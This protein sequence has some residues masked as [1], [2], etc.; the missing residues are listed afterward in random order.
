MKKSLIILF[1]LIVLCIIV[2]L[3]AQSVFTD[4][5]TDVTSLSAAPYSSLSLDAMDYNPAG[6]VFLRKGVEVSVNNILPRLQLIGKCNTNTFSVKNE[7]VARNCDEHTSW[8]VPNPSVKLSYQFGDHALAFSYAHGESVWRGNGNSCYDETIQSVIPLNIDVSLESISLQMLL[9][10]LEANLLSNQVLQ[11]YGVDVPAPYGLGTSFTTTIMSKNTQYGCRSDRFS[12]GYSYKVNIGNDD[13]WKY[14]SLYTGMKCQRLFLHQKTY[15]APFCVNVGGHNVISV[16]D[17]CS[18]Y[19]KFYEKLSLEIPELS[20]YYSK[21]ANKFKDFGQSCDTMF[22]PIPCSSKNK[23][24]GMNAV[25]GFDLV[26][27]YTNIASTVEFGSL[28]FKFS[29]GCSHYFGRCQLSIGGDFGF[30]DSNYGAYSNLFYK[31]SGFRIGNYLYG[32]IGADVAYRFAG[33]NLI[34]RAGTTFGFNKDVLLS[35]GCS[36]LLNKRKIICSPSC[37]FEWRASNMFTLV[38]GIR[39]YGISMCRNEYEVDGVIG[40]SAKYSVYP[41][42]QFSVGFVAHLE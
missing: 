23:S 24:W 38:G 35:D 16:L 4:Y 21:M 18:D 11:Q 37:G 22:V 25:L 17:L 36:I 28:P 15:T 29:I 26:Y 5:G 40:S 27:P 6:N 19:T 39:C 31:Q 32:D 10:N 41:E 13:E 34:L 12:F 33:T 9:F 42:C 7:T 3:R 2:P 14:F 30:A 8:W 1:S 20:D